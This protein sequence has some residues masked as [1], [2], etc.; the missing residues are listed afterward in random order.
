MTEV[1]SLSSFLQI[2]TLIKFSAIFS[3]A[4]EFFLMVGR[5][6]L[7]RKTGSGGTITIVRISRWTAWLQAGLLGVTVKTSNQERLKIIDLLRVGV[8]NII[9]VQ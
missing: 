4:L 6:R 7:L 3:S 8:I 2:E 1:R 5:Y 9:E